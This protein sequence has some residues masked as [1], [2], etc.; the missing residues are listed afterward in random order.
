MQRAD[1]E[2]QEI[3]HKQI[4]PLLGALAEYN[5]CNIITSEGYIL[6]R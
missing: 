3:Q 5:I 1:S 4:M 2:V 6:E